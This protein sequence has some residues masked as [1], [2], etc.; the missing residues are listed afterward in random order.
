MY[1]CDYVMTGRTKAFTGNTIPEIHQKFLNEYKEAEREVRKV[2]IF[3]T[4]VNFKDFSMVLEYQLYK[5]MLV[6]A[7]V[8]VEQMNNMVN[9]RKR[10]IH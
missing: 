2:E 6:S 10:L 1:I 9:E 8:T 5:D 4:N 7:D 3:K